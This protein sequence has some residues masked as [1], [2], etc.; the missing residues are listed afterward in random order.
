MGNDDV[1]H[2]EP[3]GDRQLLEWIDYV[4]EERSWREL[5]YTEQSFAAQL[6]AAV[7]E[8]R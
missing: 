1:E 6:A 8:D 4:A 3:L 7:G 2:V 5:R